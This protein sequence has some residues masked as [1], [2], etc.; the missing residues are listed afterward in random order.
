MDRVGRMQ[1]LR[2]SHKMDGNVFMDKLV[3]LN[4][5]LATHRNTHESFSPRTF[6]KKKVTLSKLKYTT[7]TVRQ[8]GEKLEV[9][10]LID[11]NIQAERST[12]GFQGAYDESIG[13]SSQPL[14]PGSIDSPAPALRST[15]ITQSISPRGDKSGA[16]ALR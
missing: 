5:A 9:G 11:L 13:H 7:S 1:R 3:G 2:K 4:G 10:R 8:R 6:D 15:N 16:S 14:L 12:R